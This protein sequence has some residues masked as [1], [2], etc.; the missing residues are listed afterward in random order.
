MNTTTTTTVE[1][2]RDFGARWA[3]AELGGDTETLAS[4]AVD[5]FTLVGPLGF[6][7]TREQ[8]LDRYR[9]GD[10]VT[11]QLSWEAAD[12][13]SYGDGGTAIVIGVMEQRAAYRGNPADGRFRV[14]QVLARGSGAEPW[15]LAGLH[16]SPIAEPGRPA[17]EG[18]AR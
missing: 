18:G 5:D 11:H 14:T 3:A 10:F 8:W 13:R 16:L 12:I 7:L 4:L 2:V 17:A 9:S 1:Q 6:V 15:R